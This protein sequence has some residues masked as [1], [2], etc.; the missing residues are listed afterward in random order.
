MG[1][2][3]KPLDKKIQEDKNEATKPFSNVEND[4]AVEINR[5][6]D[7]DSRKYM[8]RKNEKHSGPNWDKIS[9]D[10]DGDTGQNAGVF[11]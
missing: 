11:K 10:A 1:T 5:A 6:G 4:S 8:G 7:A 2:T 3:N 9:K